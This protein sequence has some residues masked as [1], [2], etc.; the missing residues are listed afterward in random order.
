MKKILLTLAIVAFGLMALGQDSE[1]YKLGN[2]YKSQVKAKTIKLGN[3][4]TVQKNATTNAL[5]FNVG[6]TNL[7]SLSTAGAWTTVSTVAPTLYATTI[8]GTTVAA[9]GIF[10]DSVNDLHWST[11]ILDSADIEGMYTTPVTII[12]VDA[13]YIYEVV[14]AFMIFDG[15]GTGYT[16]G[17]GVYLEYT[18]DTDIT[19][20]IFCANGPRA[21]GDKLMKFPMLNPAGGQSFPVGKAVAV[22][23]AV[24]AF[25]GGTHVDGVM[26]IKVLY[27]KIATGL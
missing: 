24:R 11:T 6:S 10:A 5:E 1:N 25:V 14:A 2:F 15:M 9:N 13:D 26:T 8:Y 22:T 21:T 19:D 27:R 23:N 4:W 16:R 12:P 7:G 17:A 18:A 3:D 20:T